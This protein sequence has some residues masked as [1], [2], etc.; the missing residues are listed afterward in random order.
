MH[1]RPLTE[2]ANTALE[3]CHEHES[4]KLR[5]CGKKRDVWGKYANFGSIL[6]LLMS[7]IG[8]V[9]NTEVKI[10]IEGD[11]PKETLEDYADR[12]GSIFETEA[13]GERSMYEVMQKRKY[14]H[15]P[16]EEVKNCD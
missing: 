14:G 12:I 9:K 11:L 7:G 3:I 2:V 4:I 16:G 10:E 6:S 1:A 15:Y 8:A 13:P 5:I